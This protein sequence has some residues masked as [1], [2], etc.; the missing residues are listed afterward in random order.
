MPPIRIGNKMDALTGAYEAYKGLSRVEVMKR[1]GLLYLI[2]KGMI[3]DITVPLI[4]EDD[5]LSTDRFYVWNEGLRQPVE[6]V[7]TSPEKI[8][9]YIDRNRLHKVA[10]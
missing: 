6:F 5:T 3:S 2:Q 8:D 1:G 10:A 7:F 9:L 4:P